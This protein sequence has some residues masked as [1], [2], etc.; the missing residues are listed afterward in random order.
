MTG[1]VGRIRFRHAIEAAMPLSMPLRAAGQWR[2]ALIDPASA[3]RT[4][5]LAL[6]FYVVLWTIYGTI[7]KSSQGLHYD[8]TEVIAWSRDLS[9]GYLKHPP[10]AA[11]LV[12]AWFSVF[13][14]TESS[15]Y[16]LAMLMPAIALWV[17]WRLSADYLDIEKRVAGLALL[18]FI[19]FFN[20]HALK[21]NV[22]TVLMPVWAMTTFWF[23][24]SYR[25]RSL[26]YAALAGLG[27]AACMLGKYWSVFLL[28]GLVAAALVDARRGIYFRSP[29]PWITV[30]VGLAVLSPHL[31]WLVQHDFAP[32]SYAFGIHGDKPFG[33]TLAAAFGYVGGSIGYV[34]IPVIVV[35]AA[36][37][38]SRATVADMIWPADRERRL[39]A[40]AFWLPFLLPV[41]GARGRGAEITSLWS[42]AAWTLLPVLLLS[43]PAVTVSA[44][45]TRRLLTAAAALPLVMLIASP[46]IAVMVQRA[47]PS[48][49]TAQAELLAAEIERQWHAETPQPLRFVGGDAGLAFSV[50]A[51]AKDRPRVLTDMPAPDAAE[52]KRSGAVVVCFV[53]DIGCAGAGGELGDPVIVTL[54]R[55]FWRLP[56]A[57]RRYLIKIVRPRP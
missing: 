40:A 19:P 37:Q 7:A 45:D 17:A 36:A 54:A 39:A 32:F 11:W 20:F 49:A 56:G 21:F 43:S 6:A 8:M 23:L 9:L 46:L 55:N 12:R 10:L 29:A 22:N 13:P 52:L 47:G 34:A 53:E 30:A 25:T 1:L 57:P 42:M 33:A 15:Y 16:L 50:A 38:P 51:Y 27:A 18:T 14:V 41:I 24:R 5:L 28:A 44:A 48:P 31:I 4:V 2:A 26:T 35:L 3:E